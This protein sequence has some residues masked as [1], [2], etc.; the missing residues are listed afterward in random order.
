[1]AADRR[2]SFRK[3]MKLK[4]ICVGESFSVPTAGA[5][6]ES[7][8]PFNVL[9]H[10]SDFQFINIPDFLAALTTVRS[11]DEIDLIFIDADAHPLTSVTMF[12]TQL[13]EISPWLPLVVFSDHTD[14]V[15]RYLLR[16]GA[17]WHYLKNAPQIENLAEDI[18]THIF[19][20]VRWEDV[21]DYYARDEIKPRLEPGIGLGD[22]D[23]LRR[24]PEEQYIIKR[25]FATSDVIQIFRMDEG[26]S[27]SRIYTVKPRHQL[28]RILKIGTIDDMEAVQ[29][30]QE[31]LIQPRLFRQV[32]QIRGKVVSA[33]HLAGACYSL[34][35]SSR[36]AMTLTQFLQDQNSVRRE[37]LDKILYQLHDSLKEL[38]SGSTE[39][40]M[41]YWAPLYSRVLPPTMIIESA[42]WVE[43][44]ESASE[45]VLDS[46]DL[47]TVSTVPNYK[48]LNE[49]NTA[50]REGEHPEVLLRNFEV[51]EVYSREGILYLQDT[52]V[53]QFPADPLLQDKEHPILRFKVFLQP[54]QHD[55]LNHPVFRRGK[56]VAIRGLV[57]DTQETV[58]AR[59]IS[60]ITG[61]D[62]DFEADFFDLA[63]AN[64][65]S[66]LE[67]LRFLL[68][69]VGREDMI[70]PSPVIAPVLHGDLN[71]GNILLEANSDVPLWLIDFSEARAGHLYFDL[72][73][74]EVEFRTHVFYKLFHEMVMEKLW[75]ADTTTKFILLVENLLLRHTDSSFEAF[76]ASLRDYQ[77]DWY[78]DLYTQFP[79]YFENLLYFLYSLRQVAH[80]LDPE[81]FQQHYP[82][83]I[84]FQSIAVLKYKN[85]M[86]QSQKLWARRLA[87]CCSLVYGKEAVAQ[88]KRPQDITRLLG[89]L[90]QRSAL[91]LIKVGNG[92]ECK[93]LMQWNKNWGRFNLVGG[94]INNLYG[95]RD[96]FAR[97]LQ[98]KLNEELGIRSPKDYHIISECSPVVRQQFSRRQHIFKDYEF[99]VFEIELLPRH[100]RNEQEFAHF[101]QRFLSGAENVLLTPAEI[102]HLRTVNGRP[103]SET[104]RIVLQIVGEIETRNTQEQA[105]T[106]AFHL[107]E[108][109]PLVTRG[110]AQISGSLVNTGFGKLIENILVEVLPRPGYEIE[111]QS[112]M[113]HIP[114]LD[115]G[116]D[117]PLEIGVH[118]RE[119]DTKLTLRITYY[120]TRG[121]EFQ[122]IIEHPIQFRTQ[123]FSL[124]Q[125]D[126]PYIVGKPLAAGNEA[127][128]VGRE[129]VFNWI[130]STLL[131]GEKSR[132]LIIT[133]Q[134]RVGKT[135]LLLQLTNGSLGKVI[136]SHA[137]GLFLPIYL[138][139][140]DLDI[141]H[142]SELFSKLSQVISR[143][144]RNRGITVPAPEIWPTS[145]RGYRLFD[146]YLDQVENVLPA[147]GKFIL[148]LDE[149]DHLR[150]LIEEGWITSDI[151]PYL[152]SLMQ[153]RSRIALIL[154]GTNRLSEE[155]WTLIY[156]AAESRELGPLTKS[157]TEQLIR[158][159]AQP[160]INFD[161][162]VVER[163][164]RLTGGHPYLTQLVCNR[165]LAEINADHAHPNLVTQSHLSKVLGILLKEDDGY[166]LALWENTPEDVQRVLAAT[167]SC[168]R[169]AGLPVSGRDVARR[170]SHD[171]DQDLYQERLLESFDD[172]NNRR[173]LLRVPKTL[174]LSGKSKNGNNGAQAPFD[175]DL[176]LF[177]FDLLRLWLTENHPF[178]EDLQVIA[179]NQPL[180]SPF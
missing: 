27:G 84:F 100:P 98:R 34:A 124:F 31:T 96:S 13:R 49:I 24:N 136:R 69:E 157:Q 73:K 79:L 35:G 155:F 6:S 159:P 119:Q 8:F 146:Q 70:V 60:D 107:D 137:P 72:A 149:L 173:L 103:V 61:S 87:L 28:K 56:K 94:R 41:R 45:Y 153:H 63:S 46:R 167:A 104:T 59:Q 148:I 132:S 118:P 92:E 53:E 5:V 156:N 135:S 88:S 176:Y 169:E 121:N 29:E 127:M 14:D 83:A 102:N 23:S 177:A 134:P 9:A 3:I 62:Y 12:V 170:L 55:L 15:M 112:A 108:L 19:L 74:L 166:L 77:S 93:Y 168:V 20:P 143:T 115:A 90:R 161:D 25:L 2:F 133:G 141:R 171:P 51:A 81:R 80:A 147:D 158:E 57:S 145:D 101:E 165:L 58:L 99:R 30:K 37:L 42:V 150:F 67:N 52:L 160:Q 138:N 125:L 1:M 164:W 152:R 40:E 111:S 180:S 86:D 139:M 11:D 68:W 76:T 4:T 109:R 110:R 142:D 113:F 172:L 114:R 116:Y 33:Q 36:D 128:F 120:D 89:H 38:Y 129:N 43:D 47:A 117:Y 48:T 154:G 140:Q 82:V 130:A 131:A 126:N 144:L 175:D 75:N 32:G 17:T 26:F 18:N 97:T 122:Q 22:L 163:I 66:P 71:A 39:T 54:S 151:L 50:V 85:L 7:I 65:L 21:F 162:L 178:T 95:D 105:T 10:T 179:Q 16:S 78:D 174:D 64:F 44:G 106:L 91:A 123:V